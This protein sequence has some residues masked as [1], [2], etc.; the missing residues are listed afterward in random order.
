MRFDQL[1]LEL[2]RGAHVGQTLDLHSAVQAIV[3]KIQKMD[4]AAR[5]EAVRADNYA[6][7]LVADHEKR[8]HPPDEGRRIP[9]NG[10]SPVAE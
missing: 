6:E 7:L 3:T 2:S 5:E 10:R 8:L 1:V 9:Y 4:T